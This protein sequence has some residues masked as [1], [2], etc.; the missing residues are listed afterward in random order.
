MSFR[1]LAVLGTMLTHTSAHGHRERVEN[2]AALLLVSSDQHDLVALGPLSSPVLEVVAHPHLTRG[3]V[4]TPCTQV[5]D[6]RL[7]RPRRCLLAA[8]ATDAPR[9]HRQRTRQALAAADAAACAA[10]ARDLRS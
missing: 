6:A 9:H 8:V 5:E 7:R 1:T 2:H 3:P 4:A 10:A